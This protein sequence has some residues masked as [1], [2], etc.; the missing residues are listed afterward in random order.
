MQY[1]AR[2][3]QC[4]QPRGYIDPIAINVIRFGNHV[5][6][7]DADAEPDPTLFAHLGLAPDHAALHLHGATHRINHTREL[8]QE[9]VAG[10]FH[11]AAPVLRDLGIN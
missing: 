8:G 3:R 10:V 1:G 4:L 5:A 11:D 7:V 9:A 2:F 6:E